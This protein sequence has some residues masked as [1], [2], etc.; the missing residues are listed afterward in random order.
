MDDANKKNS[1]FIK[2]VELF[3]KKEFYDAHEYWEELWL[4]YYLEDKKFVQAL[5]QLTVAYYHLSTGNKKGALSLFN[6]SLD[7]MKTFTPDNRGIDVNMII[8]SI[9]QVIDVEHDN[10]Y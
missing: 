9:N 10:L 7:K 3:N 4:E 5:I 1:L 6:K 2:G 8:S